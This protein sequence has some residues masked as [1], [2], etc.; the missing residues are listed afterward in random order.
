MSFRV[1][2]QEPETIRQRTYHRYP[3]PIYEIGSNQILLGR[4]ASNSCRYHFKSWIGGAKSYG[5][6]RNENLSGGLPRNRR[7]ASD[8]GM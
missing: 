5:Y 3:N 2:D 6:V 4:C 7:A 1:D 8:T